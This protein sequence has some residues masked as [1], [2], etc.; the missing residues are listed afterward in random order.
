MKRKKP[1]KPRETQISKIQ[2]WQK[3][4]RKPMAVYLRFQRMFARHNNGR[5][6]RGLTINELGITKFI[7]E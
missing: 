1:N 7:L 2:F 6:I 4:N 3:L 5:W